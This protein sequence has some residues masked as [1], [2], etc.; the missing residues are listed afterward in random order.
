MQFKKEYINAIIIILGILVLSY[1]LINR[2][3]SIAGPDKDKYIAMASNPWADS[4]LNHIAPFAYRIMFPYLVYGINKLIGNLEWSFKFLNY[5]FMFL[6]M[7]FL[8]FYLSKTKG[9]SYK[10]SILG[11]GLFALIPFLLFFNLY[12]FYLVDSL[13]YL[14]I[15][16]FLIVLESKFKFRS[17]WIFVLITFGTLIKEFMLVFIP[18]YFFYEFSKKKDTFLKLIFKTVF[19]GLGGLFVFVIL[20]L[21]IPVYNASEY[22]AFTFSLSRLFAGYGVVLLSGMYITLSLFWVFAFVNL[23][24]IKEYF[25]EKYILVY[26]ILV[27]LLSLLVTDFPRVFVYLFPFLIPLLINNICSLWQRSKLWEY[28]IILIFGFQ[29]MLLI[30]RFSFTYDY[31]LWFLMPTLI[32]LIIEAIFVLITLSFM[33]YF[34]IKSSKTKKLI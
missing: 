6:T 3:V 5:I 14:F 31:N 34:L 29:F 9:L 17:F 19:V 33:V 1:F 32:I 21:L 28:F 15:I 30:L 26:F 24:L 16:L 2:S 13:L 18:I 10:K 20:H 27:M 11:S 22:I 7:F 23:K 12:D 25:L 8:F 4:N